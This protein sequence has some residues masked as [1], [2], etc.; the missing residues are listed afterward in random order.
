MPP[1]LK[2]STSSKASR[3]RTSSFPVV[4]SIGGG[5]QEVHL[6][7][8]YAD[9]SVGF[10]SS[11][12][13]RSKNRPAW[14]SLIDCKYSYK[15]NDEGEFGDYLI[16]TNRSNKRKAFRVDEL[17]PYLWEDNLF[18]AKIMDM[19]TAGRNQLLAI[20]L[21]LLPKSQ[22]FSHNLEGVHDEYGFRVD[23][24]GVQQENIVEKDGSMEEYKDFVKQAVKFCINVS[25]WKEV[26]GKVEGGKKKRKNNEE[27]G[28]SKVKKSRAEQVKDA[29]D[30]ELEAKDGLEKSFVG[31]YIGRAEVALENLVLSPKVKIPVS[32]F[33]VD[34][35]AKK[36]HSRPD[37]ALL[38][39]TVCP[40]EGATFSADD[41]SSNSYEVIH[42]RHRL[43]ALKKLD[44]Q[45]LLTE[46][47]GKENKMVTCHI[48]RTDCMIQAN[49]GALRG[50]DVQADYVRKPYLHELVY[51]LEGLRDHYSKEKTV[52]TVLR[53]GKVL[54]FGHDDIT[55]L[56]KLGNWPP[57]SLSK[58]SSIFKKFESFQT[59]DVKYLAQRHSSK[60]MKGSTVAVPHNLFRK[61]A[62][63]TTEYLETV[64]DK[65]LSKELSLKEATE[66]FAKL[67]SRSVTMASV[68][69]QMAGSGHQTEVEIMNAFPAKFTGEVLDSFAGS[70]IGEKGLNPKGKALKDYCKSVVENVDA[71]P[72]AIFKELNDVDQ[73]DSSTM[74]RFETIVINCRKLTP[75]QVKRLE[76]VKAAHIT[77]NVI[78]LFTGQDEKMEAFSQLETNMSNLKEI[79][80]VSDQP[81]RTGD[82]CQ[83]LKLGIV[84]APIVFKPPLKAFNGP[85]SNLEEVVNQ[86][87][88][89]G[90]KSI[91]INEANLVITAIHETHSC[92]YY[93]E[94]NALARL[95]KNLRSGTEIV[96]L[97][98]V[99]EDALNINSD[100]LA[101]KVN[102]GQEISKSVDGVGSGDDDS[103]KDISMTGPRNDDSGIFDASSSCTSGKSFGRVGEKVLEF[104]L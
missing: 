3:K 51:I 54:E 42:G 36:I 1:K 95:D 7:W 96:K 20:Y 49:Y 40:A 94:K 21:G 53:F 32:S 102:G 45:G 57:E 83:N 4:V 97:D 2:R 99:G 8:K 23:K 13:N 74:S 80:F 78:V 5:V 12:G 92:E 41:L 25:S 44:Q 9:N 90:G 18:T 43:Q 68:V 50:N 22:T 55:A 82:Y 33:R 48:V 79:F 76:A 72:K 103:D 17:N 37:P 59:K 88:P 87:T 75:E 60:I 93:G 66:N 64:V 10:Y 6:G 47:V 35:L 89:P 98:F 24:I 81:V 104:N 85:M 39:L 84:S 61:I 71:S 101:N 52:E 77:T 62:K 30:F 46:V 100:V 69:Q 11:C 91:F 73:L 67:S 19:K 56:K 16:F 27:A 58:L 38:S 15:Q 34:G 63:M 29:K 26:M 14:G 31:K 70:V 28:P 65:I 86:I